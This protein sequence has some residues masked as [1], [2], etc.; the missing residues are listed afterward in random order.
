MLYNQA[1]QASF[2]LQQPPLQGHHSLGGCDFGIEDTIKAAEMSNRAKWSKRVVVKDSWINPLW[3][4]MEGIILTILQKECIKGVLILIH[5]QQVKVA[6]PSSYLSKIIMANN[7]MHTI[8]SVVNQPSYYFWLLSCIITKP[9]GVG[10]IKFFCLGKLLVA[11]L[12]YI[13]DE[14]IF[15]LHG[16]FS[17]VRIGTL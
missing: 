9:V 7:S 15:S 16:Q 4:Y 13:V 1:Y 17:D 6:H 10:I 14:Y 12:N 2:Y 5:E 11:F 8:H 3:K